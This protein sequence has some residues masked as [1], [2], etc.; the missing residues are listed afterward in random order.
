MAQS[1]IK[2]RQDPSNLHLLQRACC[3]WDKNSFWFSPQ[4]VLFHLFFASLLLSSPHSIFSLNHLRFGDL[5]TD[6]RWTLTLLKLPR[7]LFRPT[8]IH[9]DTTR[10]DTNSP[11]VKTDSHS[12]TNLFRRRPLDR[13]ST[14]TCD[15]VDTGQISA[16][17]ADVPPGSLNCRHQQA[18][19]QSQSHRTLQQQRR[20]TGQESAAYSKACEDF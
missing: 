18:C 15:H 14:T 2:A 16:Q 9:N 4:K 20:A 12:R 7:S 10:H 6:L 3:T 11:H 13:F 5:H 19:A 1:E 8:P 17:T